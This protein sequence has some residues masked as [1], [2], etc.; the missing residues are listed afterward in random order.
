[1]ANI[2]HV[3]TKPFPP[4]KTQNHFRLNLFLDEVRDLLTPCK[5]VVPE[6]RN[7]PESCFSRNDAKNWKLDWDVS[8]RKALAMQLDASFHPRP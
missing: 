6:T 3:A 5:D 8:S 4:A 7:I 1:M 2:Q